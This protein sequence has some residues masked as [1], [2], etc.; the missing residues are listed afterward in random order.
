MVLTVAALAA[1]LSL[2]TGGP[3]DP[4]GGLARDANQ[5]LDRIDASLQ[6]A[7]RSLTS[8]QATLDG[9]QSSVAD[10]SSVSGSLSSSM[11]ALADASGAQ[12][13]GIQPFAALA[14]RF[15]ELA[16]NSASLARSLDTTQASI[17]TSRGDLARLSADLSDLSRTLSRLGADAEHGSQAGGGSA[18]ALRLLLA[19]VLTWLA[20]TAALSLADAWRAWRLL[21]PSA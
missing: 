16:T 4:L 20:A 15:R 8:A 12:V 21:P 18:L 11:N 1:A 7:Q 13:L 2:G 3:L 19:G 5:A 14:P 10:A 6:A 17:G 9:A